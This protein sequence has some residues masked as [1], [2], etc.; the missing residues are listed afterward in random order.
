MMPAP[1]GSIPPLCPNSDHY[2]IEPLAR[3][4]PWR[5]GGYGRLNIAAYANLLGPAALAHRYGTFH[6]APQVNRTGR[7]PS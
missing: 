2:G 6:V 7:R 3:S 5:S 1:R 4:R